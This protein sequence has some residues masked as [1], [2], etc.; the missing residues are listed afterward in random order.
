MH[1]CLNSSWTKLTAQ[2]WEPLPGQAHTKSLALDAWI[3]SAILDRQHILRLTEDTNGRYRH[4][5]EG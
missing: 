2:A 5:A 4:V 3:L 1:V